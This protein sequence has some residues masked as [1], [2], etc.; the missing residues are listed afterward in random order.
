MFAGTA[1]PLTRKLCPFHLTNYFGEAGK[2]FLYLQQKMKAFAG[3]E[4]VRLHTDAPEKPANKQ[5]ISPQKI[6][7]SPAANARLGWQV[8]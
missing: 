8:K 7:Y 3:T 4:Q 2:H 1:F 6:G 5:V